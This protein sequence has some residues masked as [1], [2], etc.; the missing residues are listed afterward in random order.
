MWPKT[1]LGFFLGLLLS[2]SLVLNLNLLLPF[3][4][5]AKLMLGLILAFPIWAGVMTWSYAF[6][7]AGA[8]SKRLFTILIPSILLNSALLLMR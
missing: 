8:A 1:L 4:E 3:S 6:T 7:T 2:I 5:A